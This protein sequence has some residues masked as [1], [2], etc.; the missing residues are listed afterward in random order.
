MAAAMNGMALHGGFI[1]FGGTFLVLHRLLPRP[2]IRLSALMGQRVVYVMTHDLDRPGRG[3]PDPPAGRAS[4]RLARHPEPAGLPPLRQRWRRR[5][6]GRWRSAPKDQPSILALTRQALPHLR[7]DA[8]SRQPLRPRRLCHP[9]GGRRAEGD[10]D[11]HRLRS[12]DRGRGAGAAG[13]GKGI[14]AAV[15]S[16]PCWELFDQQSEAYRNE[17]LGTGVRV[18]VE[19][20]VGVRLGTLSRADRAER[21]RLRRH[22]RLRRLGARPG[23]LQ[24]FQHHRR[25]RR[26]GR[27]SQTV[28]DGSHARA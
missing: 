25:R 19:A 18:A 16:L 8:A 1:P 4:G 23:R 21:R 7:A 12:V 5:N 3:R 27:Q 2:S 28:T 10:P 6:A 20:T 15:V 17:V 9:P 13:Q 22:E 26:R 24:A 11:G 14:G